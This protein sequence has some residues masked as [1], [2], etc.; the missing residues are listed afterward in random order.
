MLG[1]LCLTGNFSFEAARLVMMQILL[2]GHELHPMQGLKL[3]GPAAVFCLGA[4]SA[5]TV[6]GEA[7]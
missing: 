6:S 3:I 2:V 7:Q 1:L 5:A 4:M